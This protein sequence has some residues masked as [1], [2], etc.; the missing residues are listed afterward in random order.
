SKLKGYEP[1]EAAIEPV[2]QQLAL[3]GMEPAQYV[4]QLVA[5]DV[6]LRPKPHDA[7]RWIAQTCGI[8]LSQTAQPV[9]SELDP[10]IAPLVQKVTNRESTLANFQNAQQQAEAA[11]IKG[12]MEAFAKDHP[13]FEKVRLHMG[14]L[15]QAGTAK[16]LQ[17]AYDMA[18]W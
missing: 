11:R 7:I 13:H 17:E 5:A 10:T 8:D 18:V 6:F 9:E 1:I 15:I 14:A 3:N 2:R 4:R 16:G 12:E